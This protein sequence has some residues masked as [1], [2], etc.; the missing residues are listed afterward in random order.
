MYKA[1]TSL[2]R[3]PKQILKSTSG[4]GGCYYRNQWRRSFVTSNLWKCRQRGA[5]FSNKDSPYRRN[6]SKGRSWS[7]LK[8][9]QKIPTLGLPTHE[10]RW[11]LVGTQQWLNMAGPYLQPARTMVCITMCNP[12]SPPVM[13]RWGCQGTKQVSSCL[14]LS[15]KWKMA[16]FCFSLKILKTYQS[17]GASPHLQESASLQCFSRPD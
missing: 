16:D 10:S 1:Y 6:F 9:S 2:A 5:L 14:I 15:R 8:R 3:A 7:L 11:T 12:S 13:V 4:A 17:L